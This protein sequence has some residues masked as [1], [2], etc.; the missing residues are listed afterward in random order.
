MAEDL[1]TKTAK[2]IGWGFADNVLG[3]GITAVAN[4]ILARILSPSDFG[5]IGMTA[6]FMTLSTS[7]VDSGFTG[8][9]TR[10]K[11][12]VKADFDTVFYF[13]L[14]VSC[15]LYAVLFLCAPL[16]AGFFSNEILVPIVRIL[17][18][19]LVINA[20][21]IVQ[22]V[23][24]VRRI[25]FR[26]QAWISLASS[27]TASVAAVAAAFSGAGVWSLVVLQVVKPAVNTVLLWSVSKW[28]PG[29]CFSRKSFSDM[30][31]FGGRLLVTS[32]ISTL[33]SEMYSVIIGRMYSS[34]VLGQYSR[35]DKVKNMV[36]SNVSS[37]MQKVSYPVLSSIQDDME[38]QVNV[39]RKVLR[40][41]VLISFTAVF[42]LWA[43]AGPFVLTVFGD[44]WLPAVDYLRIMCFSGLFLP[45][46]MCSA[47][48]INADG[49]S[50]ITLFLEILKTVLGLVP[51]VFGILFSVEALLWSMV[52][53]SF[54]LY[55]AHALCVSKVIHYSMGRQFGD[56]LPSLCVS[57][58]MAL[59]VNLMNLLSMPC[60]ILLI[61]QICAGVLIVIPSY[62]LVYKSDEYRDIKNE[63]YRLIGRVFGK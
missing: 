39:Y 23:I 21:G 54:I 7:L 19:S 18:I 38:R 57:I 36:T 11:D 45:L 22:K 43:V 3:L 46:M 15:L 56:I 28:H 63:L 60:W 17:G 24:L 6:I 4:I 35:A 20:F 32:I 27:V 10:K 44:Q 16:I 31:S 55:I 42:G 51:V 25:D 50:D 37:V 30:F 8:A 12:A 47:N 9:L 41:T 26:T 58:V 59:I 1:K 62:E 49:R 53:V 13:N 29:L 61:L 52:G 48:V 34:S 5:I 33:W 14:A 40:T 2:G